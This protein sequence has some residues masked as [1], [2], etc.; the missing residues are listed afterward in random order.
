[1]NKE[2]YQAMISGLLATIL[3]KEV[4]LGKADAKEDVLKIFDMIDDLDMFW[5]SSSEFD[6][7]TDYFYAFIEEM[8]KQYAAIG[9]KVG[10][11]ENDGTILFSEA[12]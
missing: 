9:G 11:E 2:I 3:E 1:M 4:V 5:N 7:D 10:R 12:L 8:R 6:S